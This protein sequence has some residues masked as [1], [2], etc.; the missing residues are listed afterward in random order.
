MIKK[1]IKW[2]FESQKQADKLDDQ[3]YKIGISLSPIKESTKNF[4]DYS[5]GLDIILEDVDLPE[6]IDEERL[7]EDFYYGTD[8]ETF[9]AEYGEVFIKYKFERVADSE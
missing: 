1:L 4:L 8:F 5:V 7:F 2:L 6:D 3:L 9:W